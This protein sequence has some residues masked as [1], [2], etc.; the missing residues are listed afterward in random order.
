M[1][2]SVGA[3]LHIPNCYKQKF[4]ACMFLEEVGWDKRAKAIDKF[5]GDSLVGQD[6]CPKS[7]EEILTSLDCRTDHESKAKSKT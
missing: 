3:A 4:Q 6:N 1:Q 2:N 5:N 7:V